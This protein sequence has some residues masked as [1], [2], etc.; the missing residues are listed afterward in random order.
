MNNCEQILFVISTIENLLDNGNN[1]KSIPPDVKIE[2]GMYK[3]HTENSD[4]QILV[5]NDSDLSELDRDSCQ[6]WDLY[7]TL[8]SRAETV[9]KFVFAFDSLRLNQTSGLLNFLV[10]L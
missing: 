5:E 9:V 7:I 1:F 4:G 6:L 10:T 8:L 3:I 2:I